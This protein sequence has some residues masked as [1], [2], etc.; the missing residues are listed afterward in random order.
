MRK[1][2]RGKEEESEKGTG[3]EVSLCTFY[4]IIF[5][6]QDYHQSITCSYLDF[7]F[8]SQ[9]A[10]AAKRRREKKEEA[11][12]AAMQPQNFLKA[13]NGLLIHSRVFLSSHSVEGRAASLACVSDAELQRCGRK[14]CASKRLAVCVH[15]QLPLVCRLAQRLT[16]C[17][18]GRS[19]SP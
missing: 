19:D 11:A 1:G 5:I 3:Q 7:L 13:I 14:V 17:G 4:T 6:E 15:L 9:P 10:A 16:D 2:G 12:L 8:L 18:R